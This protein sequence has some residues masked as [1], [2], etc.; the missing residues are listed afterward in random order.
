MLEEEV[1]EQI[2]LSQALENS[3]EEFISRPR[4]NFKYWC[5]LKSY[6]YLFIY[7]MQKIEIVPWTQAGTQISYTAFEHSFLPHSLFGAFAVLSGSP[8]TG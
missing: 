5:C 4:I 6:D 3:M 8:S 1:I 7:I 2:K